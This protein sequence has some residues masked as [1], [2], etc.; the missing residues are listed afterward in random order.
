VRKRVEILKV[1]FIW[2]IFIAFFL[3]ATLYSYCPSGT[4]LDYV[5]FIHPLAIPISLLAAFSLWKLSELALKQKSRIKPRK[6]F[7]VAILFLVLFITGGFP[8]KPY[9]FRDA[10]R[11]TPSREALYFK[12]VESIPNGCTVI[13]PLYLVTVSDALPNNRRKTISLWLIFESTIPMVESE[14]NGSD[15][16]YL[17][18]G[19][20]ERDFF[21]EGYEYLKKFDKEFVAR[22][23][24]NG[25]SVRIYK[26]K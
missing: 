17:V 21:R 2:L 15:C 5:R 12:A 16:V 23:V 25:K 1:G 9:L 18:E 20:F 7:L 14:I 10:R 13:S 19:G 22:V 3:S 4:C 11:E 26:I 6:E 24:E 8:V